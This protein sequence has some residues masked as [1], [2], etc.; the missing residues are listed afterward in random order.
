MSEALAV[1]TAHL[2]KSFGPVQAV[3]D[4]DLAVAPAT[5]YGILGP[6]GAGKTTTI[7]IL[8]TLLHPDGGSARV[9]GH[10]VVR[11]A[12]AVRRRI[13]LAGQSASVDED[14]TGFENLVLT[15]RLLGCGRIEARRRASELLD[16]FGLADAGGRPVKTWSGGMHRRL[17]LASTLV[18]APDLLFLDEPTTGL[19]PGSRNQIWDMIRTLVGEGATVLLTTQYLEEADQLARRVAVFDRGRVVAE[20]PPSELKSSVGAS[21][22]Q[23]RLRDPN[24]RDAAQDLLGRRLGEAVRAP[25]DPAVVTA[26]ARDAQSA[27]EAV[28]ALT[29]HGVAVTDFALGQPS[30]DQVF[31]TLTAHLNDAPVSQAVAP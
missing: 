5:V 28:T 19:D 24:Q 30:L 23:V 16:V 18:V 15:G 11:D 22:L 25:A 3:D 20:G 31:L 9:F 13:R 14:L 8:T 4:V 10:E 17:E 12:D 1:E 6:N 27:A 2:S 7:R 21:L 29:R 26:V